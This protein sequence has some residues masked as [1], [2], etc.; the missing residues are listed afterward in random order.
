MR[1]LKKNKIK[2]NI[3]KNIQYIT[4]LFKIIYFIGSNA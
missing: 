4:L 2:R 1:Y 3:M